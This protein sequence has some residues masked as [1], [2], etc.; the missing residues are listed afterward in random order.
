MLYFWHNLK[1]KK[2]Q[3][4]IISAAMATSISLPFAFEL[5]IFN[6]TIPAEQYFEVSGI[7]VSIFSL[8]KL[9]EK[10]REINWIS[11]KYPIYSISIK[12]DRLIMRSQFTETA[13][14]I[15]NLSASEERLKR[16]SAYRLSAPHSIIGTETEIQ[17]IIPR[18]KEGFTKRLYANAIL[19]LSMFWTAVSIVIYFLIYSTTSRKNR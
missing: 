6:K 18:R 10:N 8:S 13:L 11:R 12:S 1:I 17:S 16:Y 7:D 14:S 2:F 5:E 4:I 3:E 19:A 15:D 9:N